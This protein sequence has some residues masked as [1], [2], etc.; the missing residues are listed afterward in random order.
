[1][2]VGGDILWEG[3][4]ECVAFA[5]PLEIKSKKIKIFLSFISSLSYL[6]FQILYMMEKVWHQSCHQQVDYDDPF[7]VN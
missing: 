7:L 4:P 2:I 1:M 6:D 3:L 5:L